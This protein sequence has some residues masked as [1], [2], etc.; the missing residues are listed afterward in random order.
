MVCY[1]AGKYEEGI[2]LKIKVIYKI[3]VEKCWKRL[4][5]VCRYLFLL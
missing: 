5:R 1:C 2:I 4:F 3:C